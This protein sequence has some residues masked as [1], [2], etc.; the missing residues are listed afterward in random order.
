M[1][2]K[3]TEDIG[4]GKE[5]KQVGAFD[6][7]KFDDKCIT[8]VRN[9]TERLG[10]SHRNIVSGIGHD[11][12]WIN[13]VASTSMVMC[14]SHSEAE[15]ISPQWASAGTN[16]LF[17]AVVETAEIV[18]EWAARVLLNCALVAWRCIWQLQST[19]T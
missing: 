6:P 13:Q 11:A 7:L 3:I 19:V 17:H 16:E 2:K 8:A 14:L 4:L 9:D 10:Y 5:I 15:E 12:Y 1:Q 18:N